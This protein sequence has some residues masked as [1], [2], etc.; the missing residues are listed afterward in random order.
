MCLTTLPGDVDG[1]DAAVAGLAGDAMFGCTDA[2]GAF[3]HDVD[4]DVDD[5][6]EADVRQVSNNIIT[7][8]S[9]AGP[10]RVGST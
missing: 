1:D 6:E 8:S 7:T 2:G 4:H 10:A 5:G 3:A 9:A